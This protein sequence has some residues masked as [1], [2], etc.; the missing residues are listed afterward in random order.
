MGI[1]EYNIYIC[2]YIIYM[3]IYYIH[4]LCFTS[5]KL[6]IYFMHIQTNISTHL[7]SLTRQYVWICVSIKLFH[8]F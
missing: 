6:K 2:I 3:I 1:I 5:D 7:L 8:E 4:T